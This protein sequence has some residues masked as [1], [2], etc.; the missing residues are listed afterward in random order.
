EYVDAARNFTTLVE[1]ETGEEMKR[2]ALLEL[3]NVTQEQ[4]Q[5]AKSQQILAQYLKRYPRDPGVPGV[6]LRQGL[7]YRQMG[8]PA[9]ALSK[10]Y[11]VMTSALSL[12]EGSVDY[13]QRLVLH[14]QT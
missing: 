4:G 13:Y 10:F 2:L 8:A 14:A 11:A 9:L 7:L 6:L 1:N 5:L 12:K 3:A